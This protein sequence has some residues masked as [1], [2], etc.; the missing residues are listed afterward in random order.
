MHSFLKQLR[1]WF[2]PKVSRGKAIRIARESAGH[3]LEFYDVLDYKPEKCALYYLPKEPAWFILSPW[4]DGKDGKILRS[5]RLIM[6]S[7]LN[8]KI[9]YDGSAEDEG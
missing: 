9:L 5:C 7:K 8:G 1:M 6:V 2:T 3:E 4:N